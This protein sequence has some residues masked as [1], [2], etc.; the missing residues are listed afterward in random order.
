MEYARN[1]SSVLVGKLTPSEVVTIRIVKF[2]ENIEVTLDDNEC[3]ETP[4][5]G[6]YFWDLSKLPVEN[7]QDPTTFLYVMRDE[8]DGEFS[9][10][11]IWGGMTQW[12]KETRGNVQALL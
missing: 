1:D 12:V 3:A 8:S 6:Y 7:L 9:G 10:K 5:A 11:L 4:I 2:P